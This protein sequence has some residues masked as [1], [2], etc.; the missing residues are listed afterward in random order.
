MQTSSSAAV[1]IATETNKSSSCWGYA[2]LLGGVWLCWLTAVAVDVF[3]TPGGDW[4]RHDGQSIEWFTVG[5]GNEDIFGGCDVGLFSSQWCSHFAVFT[6]MQTTASIIVSVAAVLLLVAT[7]RRRPHRWCASSGTFF[8]IYSVLQAVVVGLVVAIARKLEDALETEGTTSGETSGRVALPSLLSLSSSSSFTSTEVDYGT[9]L[10]LG[11][12][13]GVVGFNASLVLLALS[14][15]A[16]PEFDPLWGCL[17]R[18]R[19]RTKS[20][21]RPAAE[22]AGSGTNSRRGSRPQSRRGSR[23][24]DGVMSPTA[25]PPGSMVGAASTGSLVGAASAASM[26]GAASSILRVSRQS[27]AAPTHPRPSGSAVDAV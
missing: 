16:P 14:R 13:C 17:C 5:G 11:F 19:R 4:L 20:K 26:V 1:T 3:V 25:L 6:V 24:S 18:N 27:L 21:T 2:A 22:S 10:L 23:C 9:T 8:A 12:C 15:Q 7:C